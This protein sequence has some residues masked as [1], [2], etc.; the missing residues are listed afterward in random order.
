MLQLKYL[1]NWTREQAEEEAT[2]CV[3]WFLETKEQKVQT[4]IFNAV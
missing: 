2:L 4:T 3:Y 1:P